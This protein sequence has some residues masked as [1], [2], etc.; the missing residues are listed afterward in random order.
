MRAMILAAGRGDRLR[1]L[2]DTVPKP[3]V[4]V[5]G[6]PLIVWHL[7]KLKACGVTEI[8]VN[9]AWLSSKIQIFL[10]DGS[11][12][13]LKIAHSVEGEQGLETAGGIIRALPFFK[14]E[15][16]VVINGD[17]FID[18]DYRQ[19]VTAQLKGDLAKLFL[20]KNPP[21]N[22]KGDFCLKDD[23]RLRMGSDFT[24][25]G[26]GVYSPKFFSGETVRRMAL[27]PF[28]ERFTAQDR[29]SGQLLKGQW[30]DVGTVE[31]LRETE[32]YIAAHQLLVKN[33]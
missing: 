7:S 30:F 32:N 15:P 17:T 12:F 19:F 8:I 28:F 33:F 24:F 16:F 20:V 22:Q 13:G 3:L 5:G 18:A 2:T 27:R 23:G 9:S 29:M 26:A 14:N 25:S 1:P 10:G 4:E 21:H 11:R 31:R 6:T